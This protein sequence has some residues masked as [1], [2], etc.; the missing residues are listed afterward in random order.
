MG[1]H[2][3]EVVEDVECGIQRAQEEE[4]IQLTDGATDAAEIRAGGQQDEHA[5]EN[6]SG[7]DPGDG[8]LLRQPQHADNR[9]D[10]E[11]AEKDPLGR[12]D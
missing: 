11:I 7:D 1:R 6:M 8:G 4:G 3:A 9:D 5:A 10:A 2:G 12:A